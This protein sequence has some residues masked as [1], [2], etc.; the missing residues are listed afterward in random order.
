[1]RDRQR[2]RDRQERDS[3]TEGGSDGFGS[4]DGSASGVVSPSRVGPLGE[5]LRTRLGL[6]ARQWT[7]VVALL[8][9]APYPVFVWLYLAYPIGEGVFLA[10]T[11]VFSVLLIVLELSL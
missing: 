1:V 7:W 8:V 4:G 11:F 2:E 9:F 3:R 10:V 6:S 5:R